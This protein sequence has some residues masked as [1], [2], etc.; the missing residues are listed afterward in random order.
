MKYNLSLLRGA[1]QSLTGKYRG[2]QG[3]PCNENRDP[4]MSTG[5][6]CNE[7]RFFPVRIYYTG[8]P[9]SGPVLALYGIA[10]Y[11]GINLNR[12]FLVPFVAKNRKHTSRKIFD[13]DQAVT[14]SNA[15]ISRCGATVHYLSDVNAVVTR[16]VLVAYATSNGETKSFRTLHTRR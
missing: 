4:V 3:N 8:K 7:N 14:H 16:N 1:L 12:F 9:C 10:V 5:V 6:P 11:S 15:A 13:C 2:L